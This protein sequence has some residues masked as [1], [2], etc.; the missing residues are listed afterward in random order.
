[1]ADEHDVNILSWPNEP[2]RL[3]HHFNSE[4]PCP[5]SLSF[6]TTPAHVILSGSFDNPLAVD[7]NMNLKVPETIPI[8]IRLCEPI[9]AESNY[10][11]GLSIFDRPLI[12]ITIRGK[13][14]FYSCNE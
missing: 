9:C 1:M 11:I 14:R 4:K 10:T 6:D 5:V 2:A 13:T 8:C 7:M 12:S 3:E